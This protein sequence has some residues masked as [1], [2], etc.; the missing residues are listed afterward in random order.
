MG[1]VCADCAR[2]LPQTSYT[3]NQWSKGVGW[4]R[5]A[6]CVHGHFSDNP[7]SQ[8]SDSGRHNNSNL[9]TFSH[10][11]L[12]NPFAS[13]AFRWVAQGSYSSGPRFRQACVA[14]W[15]KT[16]AVFEDD[17]FA[18][19]IKA[20]NK[21]LE[22]VNRFNQLNIVNKTVKINVPEVWSFEDD[23]RDDWAG[24]KVLCEPFIQDYQKF[25]SNTGWND[26][27]RAWGQVMQALSR[28]YILKARIENRSGITY[29]P[30]ARLQ[31]PHFGWQLRPLR[32]PGRHLP[33]RARPV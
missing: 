27:S 18:L 13:G 12:D 31:L 25:N 20:V 28:R 15:F 19:D 7:A 5:C 33:T 32:S 10:D 29:I 22:L 26:D 23:C 24:Q 1:R 6:G 9:A 11:A 4:S 14:K 2:D 17:Y 3:A 21:A 30:P 8:Q 16:G